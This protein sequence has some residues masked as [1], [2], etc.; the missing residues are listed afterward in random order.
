[1]DI[2]DS[3]IGFNNDESEAKKIEAD[4][5]KSAKRVRVAQLMFFILSGTVIFRYVFN[6]FTFGGYGVSGHGIITLVF[7]IAYLTLGI[8]TNYYP[9]ISIA[10]GIV[11]NIWAVFSVM[12]QSPPPVIPLV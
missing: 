3:K 7:G 4:F 5:I 10:L 11:A 12:P 6:A 2:L 9:R 1:M 8:A